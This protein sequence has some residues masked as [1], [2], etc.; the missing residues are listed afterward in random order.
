MVV[1]NMT[2]FPE[3]ALVGVGVELPEVVWFPAEEA[4]VVTVVDAVEVVEAD[5]AEGFVLS[6]VV[7]V[8]AEVVVG[9]GTRTPAEVYSL[10]PQTAS[11]SKLNVICHAAHA[12][13]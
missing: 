2:L 9:T 6:M 11:E 7:E 8:V 4:P 12:L 13:F 1:L 5:A 10:I 3:A